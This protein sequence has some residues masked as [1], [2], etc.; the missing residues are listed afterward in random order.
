MNYE[1][2]VFAGGG[3][4]CFW[5]AGFW[6][7]FNAEVELEVKNIASVSAGSAISC[8]IFSGCIEQTIDQTIAVQSR[9]KKNRYWR[10]LFNK[11]SVH[12]HAELYREIIYQ[13]IDAEGLERLKQGPKNNILVAHIP[14]WLGPR[15]GVL[16][17]LLAYQIE[18]KLKQPVHPT[19][20][21]TLGFKSEFLAASEANTVEE[22]ANIILSS[23]CTPPF[24]PLMY[25]NTKPVLD[26]GMVDNV[27]L[28][29]V[30]H[31]AAKTLVLLS[32]PYKYIP[33]IANVTYVQPSK[34][35]PI[36]SWDYT[37]PNLVKQTYDQGKDDARNYLKSIQ[38]G[39][40]KSFKQG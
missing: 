36:S 7:V 25:R 21:R 38:K 18:K 5:Q 20:G 23:S 1:N 3:N 9:N 17:G 34:P 29:G 26:G 28:H 15:T 6:E 27:P 31:E 30:D 8:A 12:P 37:S 39:Q 14:S 10:N 33:A 4:R 13:S 40:L 11:K 22:L 24:T 19:L 2:I 32:R 35:V 16:V